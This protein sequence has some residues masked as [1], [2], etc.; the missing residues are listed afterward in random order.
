M[1][2]QS[3]KRFMSMLLS[4]AFI[5]GAFLVFFE[6]I[7]PSYTD[8]STLKGQRLSAEQFLANEQ[9]IVAQ[10]KKL[11]VQSQGDQTAAQNLALAMPSGPDVAGALAQVYGIAGN[12]GVAIKTIGVSPPRTE[13]ATASAAGMVLKPPGTF[14][15]QLS[16]DGSYEAIKNF[17]SQ[18]ETNIRVFDVTALTVQPV[19]AVAAAG[20]G[21]APT[22]D[23]FD[24]TITV[25]TYYQLP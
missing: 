2:K 3:S 23:A 16:A 4:L 7:Q 14:S 21:P 22:P 5:V 8:L 12:N 13:I 15:L 25:A 9:Q 19:A 18:L 11:V 1:M 20:K 17:L 6:L 24:Y 10:V